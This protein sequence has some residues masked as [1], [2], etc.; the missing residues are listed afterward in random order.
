MVALF[1]PLSTSHIFER[2]ITIIGGLLF[3]LLAIVTIA[4]NGKV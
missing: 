2:T 4:F 3:I 1:Q